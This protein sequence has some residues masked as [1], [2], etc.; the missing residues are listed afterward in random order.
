MSRAAILK[1]NILAVAVIA[2][3]GFGSWAYIANQPNHKVSIITNAQHQTTQ[4]SYHGQTGQTALALLKTHAA[5]LTKHYSFGDM[6]TTID[7]TKGTGPRY[8]TFYVN[9]K[10]AQVGA[11]T[12]ITK[13]TDMLSWKLQ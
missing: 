8:W 1:T 11:G 4:L 13:N 9:G 7:G 5:I 10:Q 2:A 12:Y 6:V 3:L